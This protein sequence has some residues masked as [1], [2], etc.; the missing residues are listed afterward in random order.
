ME[1]KKGGMINRYKNRIFVSPGW[2]NY[3]VRVRLEARYARS[4]LL[5]LLTLSVDKD[6]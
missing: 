5:P 6:L 2:S 1:K 4:F 3:N